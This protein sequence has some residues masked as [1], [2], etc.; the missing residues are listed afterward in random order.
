M[1]ETGAVR[2]LPAPWALRLFD[3]LPASPLWGGVAITLLV[4]FAYFGVESAL[5]RMVPTLA[6]NDDHLRMHYRIAVVN[7]LFIGFLPIAHVYLARWTRRHLADLQPL[8][9]ESLEVA[10][11][12]T[13]R[14]CRV[15][16]VLGSLSVL[17]LFLILPTRAYLTREYWTLVHIWDWI[18]LPPIGWMT[19][20]LLYA[21]VAH[22]SHFSRLATRIGHLDLYDP[23]ILAPCVRQGLRSALLCVIFVAL[24]SGLWGVLLVSS[25]SGAF[26]IAVSLGIATTA[27]LLPLRGA[28]NRIREEK[29]L[30]L[31]AVR[32]R[33]R[34]AESA[35]MTDS[36][37][38]GPLVAGLPGLLALEAR[39]AAVRD[40]PLDASSLSRF[41]FYVI[42]GLGSWVGAAL[43]ERLF[44]RVLS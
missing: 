30:R 17:L 6:E 2:G 15:A 13:S 14:G 34:A 43:V 4:L 23:T 18:L 42:L 31:E 35:A 40:W 8:V 38:A 27:L 5:G 29:R 3:A 16:G 44:D 37:E 28:R 39:I 24:S 25:E 11:S 26:A 19:G 32:E 36:A 10:D 1:D 33:I 41:A 20:R 7:A 12:I 22:S 9:D 21:I